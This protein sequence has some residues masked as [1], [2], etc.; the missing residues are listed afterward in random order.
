M[1]DMG[2]ANMVTMGGIDIRVI[3]IITTILAKKMKK[4]R[5]PR[6]KSVNC[7]PAAIISN[8]NC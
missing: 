3:T 4:I 1:V 8:L 7:C 6:K 5:N 2:I